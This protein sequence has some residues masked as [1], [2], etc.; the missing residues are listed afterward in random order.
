M[1]KVF[2][3]GW[4]STYAVFQ[5]TDQVLIQA[6]LVALCIYRIFLHPLA[7]AKYPGRLSYKLSGWPL[8][9]QAYRQDRHIWHLR[10][11]EKY[12]ESRKDEVTSSL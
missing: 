7:L 4:L 6:K 3:L 2:F 11:H 8:L 1:S 9:W 12:G 10:D 5:A